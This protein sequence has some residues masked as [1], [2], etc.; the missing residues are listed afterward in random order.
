MN[1]SAILFLLMA[2]LLQGCTGGFEDKKIRKI[3]FDMG[4]EEEDEDGPKR[5]VELKSAIPMETQPRNVLLTTNPAH[6]LTPIYKVNYDL[7]RDRRFVGSNSFLSNYGEASYEDHNQWNGNFMPGFAAL[8]GYNLVN[9]SHFNT[10]TKEQRNLFDHH[11]M[12]NTLY[13][14]ANSPDTLN[15]APIQRDFYLVSVYDEDTNGDGW[16][17]YKDLRRFYH[18]DVDG[19][20]SRP[21]VPR[22][23]SVLS[24][25]YDDQIDQMY[26]FAK[27]DANGNGQMEL[28]EVMHIF[29]I[30]LKDPAQMGR[31]Y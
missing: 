20:V 8:Q 7:K 24:S 14:P 30:D 18:F 25:E 22:N 13:Y 27:E 23:Y 26:I 12:V 29:W 11:V 6:R 19:Q 21:V 5:G 9:V 10:S 3:D 2:L 31:M 1:K 4:R 17:N 28:N 15:G 16:I